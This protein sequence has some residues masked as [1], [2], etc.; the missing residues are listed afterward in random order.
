MLVGFI[1]VII[2]LLVVVGLFSSGVLKTEDG[3]KYIADATKVSTVISDLESSAKFYTI[4]G[5]YDG[6]KG[7]YLKES[8]FHPELLEEGTLNSDD[9]ENWPVDLA[10]PY[11]GT[12][13]NVGGPAG[14]DMKILLVPLNNGE[15]AGIYLIKRKNN[16]IDPRYLKVLERILAKNSKYI[17]G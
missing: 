14:D 5:S 10:S 17:A 8:D 1:L 7:D 15:S 9:W 2:V 4:N 6:I 11:T 3:S 16:S 13:V 12:Y